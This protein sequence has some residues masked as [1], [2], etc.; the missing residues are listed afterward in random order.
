MSVVKNL[1][2]NHITSRSL[3]L[4]QLAEVSFSEIVK[5]I[6][7]PSAGNTDASHCWAGTLQLIQFP[8]FNIVNAVYAAGTTLQ[9]LPLQYL[10]VMSGTKSSGSHD[11]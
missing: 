6:F 2:C 11:I 8:I 1:S 10:V 3:M 4:D 9:P 7:L 5:I